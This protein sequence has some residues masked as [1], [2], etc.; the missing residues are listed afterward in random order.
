MLMD[1]IL[2]ILLGLVIFLIKAAPAWIL[3]LIF[4]FIYKKPSK[5]NKPD[6]TFEMDGKTYDAYKHDDN[7]FNNTESLD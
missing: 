3:I 4:I 2:A 1:Y 6:F 7:A 5:D